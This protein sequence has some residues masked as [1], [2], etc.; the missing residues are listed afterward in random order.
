MRGTRTM[1]DEP[2]ERTENYNLLQTNLS[3]YLMNE[4]GVDVQAH[5]NSNR[6]SFTAA[7]IALDPLAVLSQTFDSTL[8]TNILDGKV[9]GGYYAIVLL[10]FKD[11]PKGMPACKA[12]IPGLH[13]SI[14]NPF[15][16]A[17]ESE[18]AMMISHC[19]TFVFEDMATAASSPLVPGSVIKV[20]FDNPYNYWTSGAIEKV[21][22][23]KPKVLPEYAK[24]IEGV[25]ELFDDA[26]RWV[27]ATF[28]ADSNF[29]PRQKTYNGQTIEN[30]KLSDALL[31]AVD[32]A[33]SKPG[34]VITAAAPDFNAMAQAFHQNFGVKFP[35]TEGYRSFESQVK[36]WNDPKKVNAAGKKL[37]AKP[38][39]SNHGWGV[40]IDWGTKDTNG[41]RGYDSEYYKW[42]LNN[43]KY[44]V[45]PAWALKGGSKEEPWHW[46]W[47]KKAANGL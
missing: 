24:N 10:A 1:A 38:G 31:T 9:S 28:F 35:L 7:D 14:G 25:K 13:D 17:D 5:E 41:V 46:E 20:V 18:R 33:Y 12:V 26:T 23:G 16:A 2:A 44:F 19:P 21:I 11:G 36:I 45:N 47:A 15:M 32:T 40:A 43:Q 27:N 3:A 42:M 37:G 34:R 29:T 22:R 39:T 8:S 4:I 30:G 6:S